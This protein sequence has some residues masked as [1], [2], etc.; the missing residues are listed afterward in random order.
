MNR[1][2]QAIHSTGHPQLHPDLQSL[3]AAVSALTQ[4]ELRKVFALVWE[5]MGFSFFKN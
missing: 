4:D 1:V 5:G 2:L 3:E